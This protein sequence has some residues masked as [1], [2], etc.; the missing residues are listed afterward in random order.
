[1]A[2]LSERRFSLRGKLYVTHTRFP[3]GAFSSCLDDMIMKQD[4]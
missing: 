3:V 2:D 4:I 1:M